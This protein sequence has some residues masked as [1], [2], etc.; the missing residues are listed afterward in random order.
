MT[1]YTPFCIE[2]AQSNRSNP[3]IST[4]VAG[5]LN[6]NW[7]KRPTKRSHKESLSLRVYSNDGTLLLYF[8]R[9]IFF[10]NIQMGQK[11]FAS[12]EGNI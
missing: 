2:D 7:C 4:R 6:D 11:L 1:I 10:Q 8:E 12:L 9:F 3:F 5:I